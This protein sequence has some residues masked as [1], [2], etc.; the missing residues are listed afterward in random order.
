MVK[1]TPVKI[2]LAAKP[3]LKDNQ[4][5]ALFAMNLGF[6]KLFA[7]VCVCGVVVVVVVYSHNS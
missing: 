1:N 6:R 2:T 5:G 7:G 3:H 4:M